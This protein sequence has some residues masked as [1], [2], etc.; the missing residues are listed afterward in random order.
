MYESPMVD[1]VALSDSVTA[2]NDL[3]RWETPVDPG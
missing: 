2:S 3:D 1:V